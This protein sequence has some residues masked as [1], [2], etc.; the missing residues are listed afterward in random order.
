MALLM[1]A[2]SPTALA[3]G[4]DF[5][6]TTVGERDRAR[7]VPVAATGA[8][9]RLPNRA[10]AEIM[11]FLVLVMLMNNTEHSEDAKIELPACFTK[12]VYVK[13]SL[14]RGLEEEAG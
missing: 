11:G 5:A 3:F 13:H 8:A 2:T 7:I 6:S 1:G 9:Y 10:A 14:A 12:S 4:S